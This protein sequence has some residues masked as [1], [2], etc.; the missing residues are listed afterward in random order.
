MTYKS[1]IT[2]S[3]DVTSNVCYKTLIPWLSMLY[4]IY[5]TSTARGSIQKF[6]NDYDVIFMCYR[7]NIT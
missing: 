2:H 6:D 4:Y 3:F 7:C 1:N 5:N